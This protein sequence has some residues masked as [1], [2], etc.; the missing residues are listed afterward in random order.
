[1]RTTIARHGIGWLITYMKLRNGLYQHIGIA[2]PKDNTYLIVVAD[3]SKKQI[4]GHYILDLGAM[5]LGNDEN[6]T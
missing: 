2:V 3:K 5:Y 6:N 1:M 4:Q